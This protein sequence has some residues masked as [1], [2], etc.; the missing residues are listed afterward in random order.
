MMRAL[1]FSFL[2]C[3]HYVIIEGPLFIFT[4]VITASRW[5][6]RNRRSLMSPDT[7]APSP[8]FPP[9]TVAPAR[10]RGG[11]AT[12]YTNSCPLCIPAP[13]RAPPCCSIESAAFFCT[14]L[15][16][17][18]GGTGRLSPSLPLLPA[19]LLTRRTPSSAFQSTLAQSHPANPCQPPPGHRSPSLVSAVR[20]TIHGSVSSYSFSLLSLECDSLIAA[21]GNI[22]RLCH[23]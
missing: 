19:R 6:L 10:V 14:A 23:N 3:E 8:V 5:P 11:L 13:P 22:F 9:E 18:N 4:E 21:Q 20:S 15:C 7:P 12:G 17:G 1:Y 16:R 2:G